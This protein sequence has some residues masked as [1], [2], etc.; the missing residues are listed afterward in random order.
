M[1]QT[2]SHSQ[3]ET[4]PP[5]HS[6]TRHLNCRKFD[7][8]IEAEFSSPETR[9]QPFSLLMISIHQ[10]EE[11]DE[12]PG[13]RRRDALLQKI[14]SICTR[15]VR[16]VDRIYP[17]GR[18]QF[19][20]LLRRTEKQEAIVAARRLKKIMEEQKFRGGEK[21][22][23]TIS[24][25]ISNFPQD[26]TDKEGLLKSADSAFSKAKTSHANKIF[27]VSMTNDNLQ[28]RF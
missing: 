19:S 13:H 22:K 1:E 3:V 10:H 28:E 27:L 26:A 11:Y 7:Q 14:V 12:F 25:G 17:L 2:F 23:I 5:R 16:H 15:N 21:E 24:I 8:D 9:T 20:I 4:L 18:K 6:S